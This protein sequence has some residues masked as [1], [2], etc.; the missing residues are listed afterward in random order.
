VFVSRNYVI[1][2]LLRFTNFDNTVNTADVEPPLLHRR[3]PVSKNTGSGV[4]LP[5]TQVVRRWHLPRRLGFE[6]WQN[7]EFTGK[8]ISMRRAWRYGGVW[9]V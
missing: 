2:Y 8:S 5:L 4:A 3:Q 9:G 7:E 1:V 6:S